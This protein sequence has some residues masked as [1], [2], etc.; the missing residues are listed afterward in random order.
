MRPL[1]PGDALARLGSFALVDVRDGPAFAAGHLAGSGH[2]PAADLRE[3]RS[4][5]PSRDT[6]CLV[7]AGSADEAR[8][9]AEALKDLGYTRVEWLDGGLD[10]LPGGLAS[11]EPARVLWRPAPFLEAMLPRMPKGG[12]AL[13]VAA[14]HGRESVFLAM[15][16]WD[17]TAMDR[18]PEALEKAAA[19]ATRSGTSIRTQVRDLERG[20]PGIEEAHYDAVVCFR[21]LHR[22]LFPRLER[23]LK[24]G[25]CLVY[26]TFRVGQERFGRPTHRQ[27]LLADNELSSAF[28]LLDV[29]HYAES[30]PAGGPITASLFARRPPGKSR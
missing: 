26:E 18:A 19:L 6:A 20:D 22:P 16:G 15:H 7:L 8:A 21:F 5:L 11:R 3:R 29:E 4:E 10:R 12:V 23:A 28:P 1:A 13:D 24:P 9:G 25:G 14:G 30:E 27:Y 2:V 17:V